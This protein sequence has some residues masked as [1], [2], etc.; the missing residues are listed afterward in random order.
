MTSYKEKLTVP[1]STVPTRGEIVIGAFSGTSNWKDVG[2][3]AA[4][5]PEQACFNICVC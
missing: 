2:P 5:S 4:N 3:T 1:G